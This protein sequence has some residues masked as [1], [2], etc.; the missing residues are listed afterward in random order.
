MLTPEQKRDLER[1]YHAEL[2]KIGF[3]DERAQEIVA[4]AKDRLGVDMDT[5]T[6]PSPAPVVRLPAPR[7]R[8]E[9]TMQDRATV[10]VERKLREQYHPAAPTRTKRVSWNQI[11][12]AHA[13][14]KPGT[15]F[16]EAMR[17]ELEADMKALEFTDDDV[18]FILGREA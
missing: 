16:M 13:K 14:I 6:Y 18:S 1:R 3:S 8:S 7:H 4:E 17:A 15:N 9:V 2:V 11:K 10:V 12:R 5:A